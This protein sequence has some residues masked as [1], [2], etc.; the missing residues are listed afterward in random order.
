[1]HVWA[2]YAG[3][4]EDSWWIYDGLMVLLWA[5]YRGHLG[6]LSWPYGGFMEVSWGT[7]GDIL[8]DLWSTSIDLWVPYGGRMGDC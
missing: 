1:M 4:M 5:R 2:T 8:I 7:Y 3:L 6:D